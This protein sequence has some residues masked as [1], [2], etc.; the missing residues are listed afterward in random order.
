MEY[1]NI[2]LEV[3]MRWEPQFGRYGPHIAGHAEGSPRR[4]R[5]SFEECVDAIMFLTDFLSSENL[6]DLADHPDDM[7]KVTEGSEQLL[8]E[9][10]YLVHGRW[11]PPDSPGIDDEEDEE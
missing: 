2:K 3:E 8:L 10:L 6:L 1:P 9:T 4:R 7:D 11:H 5:M